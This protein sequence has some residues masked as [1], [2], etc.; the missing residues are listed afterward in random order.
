MVREVVLPK[1][2][3]ENRRPAGEGGRLAGLYCL[4]FRHAAGRGVGGLWIAV[5]QILPASGRGRAWQPGGWGACPYL[6]D[7]DFDPVCPW[8]VDDSDGLVAG[9]SNRGGQFPVPAD[10][11]FRGAGAW[12]A[13][14]SG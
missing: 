4:L 13:F 5:P 14:P 12:E 10:R 3:T 8:G 9:R 6:D 11:R 7:R 2:A 1:A